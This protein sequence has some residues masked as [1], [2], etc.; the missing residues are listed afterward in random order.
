MRKVLMATA[1]LVAMAGAA[2]AQNATQTLTL[3]ANVGSS[4]TIDTQS[5]GPAR[6]GVVST[7]GG[8]VTGAGT[9]SSLLPLS[10][11]NGMVGCNG[12]NARI[13]LTS[14]NGAMTGPANSD[15]NYTNKITYTATASLGS[16]SIS[17]PTTDTTAAGHTV[18]SEPTT[19][20]GLTGSTPLVLT[21]TNVA[22]A[23]NKTLVPGNYIDVVTV[24]LTPAP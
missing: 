15:S 24:T 11:S 2:Q 20:S 23:P 16:T 9:G 19:G 4:C 12:M 13:Q 21:V 5:T 7:S 14:Q 22:Q 17:L 3:S 6:T 8:T 18:T 10:G 1:A